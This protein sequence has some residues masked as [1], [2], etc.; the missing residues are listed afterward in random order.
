M[1]TCCDCHNTFPIVEFR[2]PK[3]NY[4]CIECKKKYDRAWYKQRRRIALQKLSAETPFCACCGE[5][6][7]NFLGVDHINGGGNK[8]RKEL[9]GNCTA[10]VNYLFKHD[11][12]RAQ[13]QVLCWNCNM[14]KGFF[15]I[16]P[17]Q[18]SKA[19]DGSHLNTA[20][21]VDASSTGALDPS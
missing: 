16:C 5:I 21:N 13:F 19:R 10:L 18:T 14:S 3:K 2:Q 6:E 15:G 4:R 17:H 20:D 11:F 7:Y 9:K 12:P 1:R 8:H